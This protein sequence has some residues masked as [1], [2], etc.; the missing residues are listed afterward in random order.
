MSK[1]YLTNKLTPIL[2]AST[3]LTSTWASSVDCR[4]ATGGLSEC[5]PYSSRFIVAKEVKYDKQ[6]KKLIDV[7]TLPNVHKTS[8]KVVSVIDMVENSI[9]VEKSIRYMGGQ[10]RE[11]EDLNIESAEKK[12]TLTLSK[13]TEERRALTLDKLTKMQELAYTNF[14]KKVEELQLE[15]ISENNLTTDI[16]ISI[17]KKEDIAKKEEIVKKEEIEKKEKIVIKKIIKDT[18]I[19]QVEK[20]DSLI[21]IAKKFSMKKA[22]LKEL[23]GLKN[24]SKLK[25]NQKLIIPIKQALLDIISS[26]EYAVKSGDNI[27]SI[28][29]KFDL[30]SK[31][32]MKYNRLHK[33][34][35]IHIGQKIILPF[36]HKIAELKKKKRSRIVSTRGKRKLRVTATAYTSHRGQTDKTPFLAAWNNRI[37]P[38]MKIVAVSR[39]ML[40][41]YGLKNGSKIRI[42]GLPGYYTVRDKMNKRY[43]KRID[44]YMGMNRRKAL[45]WGR[46]SVMLYY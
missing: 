39:D 43:R 21:T 23:N 34:S 32:I 31:D 6:N 33:R 13:D 9:K 18:G 36:P 11:L 29:R 41:R 5:N 26:A 4:V 20:G 17:A 22:K 14:I 15:V 42:S 19:Y 28:A 30:S 10:D 38:G 12:S 45:R 25:I 3:A 2:F 16:N 37:R 46:R 24:S 8:V 40:T 1:K 7:R 44:I 35:T 27:G